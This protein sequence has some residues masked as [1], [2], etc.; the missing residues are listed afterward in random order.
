M[1]PGGVIHRR[2]R[3]VL[4]LAAAT[5]ALVP[6]LALAAGVRFTYT[7]RTVTTGGALL[8]ALS[9]AVGSFAVLRRQS[10][11]G[12]A[13][14]HA[15]LPG[16]GIAFLI[17][18]RE[19]WAL[20]LGAT[21]ASLSGVWFISV[22]T[23]RTRL[24][25]D[26]AMGIVLAGWFAVGIGILAFIQQRPDASQAGLD[27][28]IFGQAA[29]IV[30]QDIRILTGVALGSAIV[31]LANWK[32]F[33]LVSFDPEFAGA[34]GYRVSAITALLLLL[35]VIA[36]VVGLQLAG[37]VLMV[38][39]LIA[40]GIAARQWV[41]GLGPMVA[42]A[43]LFGAIAGATGAIASSLDTDLPTGPMI[44]LIASMIVLLSLLFAP[45]RGVIPV[46]VR[47][48]RDRQRFAARTVLQTCHRYAESHGRRRV[49][50][51]GE[52]LTGV[53]G[54]AAERGIRELIGRG[55]LERSANGY[56]LTSA[57]LSRVHDDSSRPSG[58]ADASG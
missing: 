2:P 14:S 39:L 10:L 19:L 16:V 25:Q 37:V 24:K 30:A 38:G 18:G 11:L 52:F 12:D 41:R 40:P 53:V 57:G 47:H 36:V 8:G 26:A 42:L 5:L 46:A 50:V 48:R 35:I 4:A 45:G 3:A 27:T 21:L 33:K 6:L 51:P 49:V 23:R 13:L 54:P 7:L 34:N 44:I 28:F 43:A 9:G 31:M 58:D 56:V 55:E 17:A 15:A 32:E 29:A 22:V 1:I 20:L